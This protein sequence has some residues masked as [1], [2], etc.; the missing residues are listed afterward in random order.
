M[1]LAAVR[2]FDDQDTF[3]AVERGVQSFRLGRQ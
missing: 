3:D 2:L 1:E